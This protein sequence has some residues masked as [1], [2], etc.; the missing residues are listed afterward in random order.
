MVSRTALRMAVE[1]PVVAAI[2]AGVA[3]VAAVAGTGIGG[4][5]LGLALTL[6]DRLKHTA[7]TITR[8]M[9]LTEGDHI[10]LKKKGELP[11]RHAIV[12]EPVRDPTDLL[13]LVY[14]SGSKSSAR[15]EFVEVDLHDEARK[16]ELVR[17]QYE[18]LICYPAQA[19]V[20][21]AV[22][23][24]SQHNSI[25]RR[26]V[27][28]MF[29]PF[30]CDD[31]HF[32]NWCQIGFCFKDGLKAALLADYTRTLVSDVARLSEGSRQTFGI[33]DHPRSGVLYNFGRVCLAVCLSLCQSIAF[34]SLGVYLHIRCI[35]RK[36]WST[37]YMKVIGS[38]SRSHEQ[39]RSKIAIHAM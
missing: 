23:L 22:G 8:L 14:H 13:R 33:F 36:Y 10:S 32:A 37:S 34:D 16:G 21:R 19:V 27:L 6:R 30:F 18:A 31:E 9:N 26:E 2:G 15:V 29:W 11:F 24:C 35:F 5:A 3:T 12:V 25:D 38:R 28:R 20:A 39:R 4:T 1:I 7:T 17:H